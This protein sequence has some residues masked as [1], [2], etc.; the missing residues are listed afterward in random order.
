MPQLVL[1]NLVKMMKAQS[2]I[3]KRI[4]QSC[5]IGTMVL[6]ILQVVGSAN[7]F[8][9]TSVPISSYGGKPAACHRT[10]AAVT[11][12]PV[13]FPLHMIAHSRSS[14][15]SRGGRNTGG[16]GGGDRL[17]S[18]RQ[19]R[20]G[21]LVRT[22]LSQIL[23]S[24]IIRGRNVE[25]LD[26]ITRKRISVVAADVS[27]DLRQ[28]RITVSIR[29]D[30]RPKTTAATMEE[31]D[32]VSDAA[33]SPSTNT[34]LDKRRAYSWLVTHAKQIR[35]TLAQRM[36]HLKTCPTLTFV[37][38]D[39]G[40]AVDVMYLIDKV[41]QGYKR[42]SLEHEF[43]E[44]EDDEYLP[45]GILGGVDFDQDIDEEEWIEDDKDFF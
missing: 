42:E 27:P 24:G 45:T 21:H 43:D 13:S 31:D 6:C 14:S 15:Y 39:V 18:K 34:A 12:R 16:G 20:V 44:D 11:N 3:R 22:E 32:A 17:S 36:S 41:A 38:V 1:S 25:Y 30:P 19:E 29:G 9:L 28:A 35:H 40:A 33:T 10:T 8:S 4:F 26:D 5:C 2:E 7:G 37:Q 23:H